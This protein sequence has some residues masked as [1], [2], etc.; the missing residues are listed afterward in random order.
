MDNSQKKTNFQLGN[1][2]KHGRCSSHG[3]DNDNDDDNPTVS[4]LV[5]LKLKGNTPHGIQLSLA[6]DLQGPLR[7]FTERNNP[8][9][10]LQDW[11]SVMR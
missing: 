11:I 10:E 1:S 8:D 4:F 7:Y 3:N 5:F 9:E 6:L 2:S